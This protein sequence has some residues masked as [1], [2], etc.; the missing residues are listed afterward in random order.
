MFRC[1]FRSSTSRNSLLCSILEQLRPSVTD[2]GRFVEI[3]IS[4]VACP[5][6]LVG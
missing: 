3:L 6:R 4:L 1:I 5:R 2:W